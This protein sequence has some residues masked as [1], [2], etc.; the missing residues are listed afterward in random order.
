MPSSNLKKKKGKTHFMDML[1]AHYSG[2]FAGAVVK[3][4]CTLVT[5]ESHTTQ[6]DTLKA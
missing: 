1:N 2:F 4:P 6:L 5:C 3:N